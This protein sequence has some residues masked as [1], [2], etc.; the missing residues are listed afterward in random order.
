VKSDQ[1]QH[2]IPAVY[3]IAQQYSSTLSLIPTSRNLARFK[4]LG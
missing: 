1:L 3:V 2:A 4:K